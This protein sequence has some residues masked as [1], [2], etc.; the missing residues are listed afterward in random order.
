MAKKFVVTG[1]TGATGSKTVKFLVDAGVEVR[2][3]VHREDERSAAL[4]FAEKGLVFVFRVAGR[5]F[6]ASL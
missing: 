4:Q 6:Q 1:S 2:A 3:F 5:D